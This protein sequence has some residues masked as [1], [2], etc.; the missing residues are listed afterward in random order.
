MRFTGRRL[1]IV[2]VPLVGLLALLDLE[3]LDTYRYPIA[4]PD[5]LVYYLAAQVGS[6]QGWAAIYD[7]SI[8]LPRITAA[9]GRPLPYLNPPQLAWLVLPLT[10]LPYSLAAWAWK[11]LL[12]AAY[13]LSS[14]LAA[15]GIR[16]AKIAWALAG[17]LMLPVFMSLVFGQVSLLIVAVIALAYWLVRTN[18]PWL[19]GLVLAASFLKPQAAFLVPVALLLSS[20]LRTF[21]AWLSASAVLAVVALLAVSW[22]A[23][24]NIAA[25]MAVAGGIPGP[26]QMSLLR[27]L[28]LPLGLAGATLAVG[29]FV[30]VAIRSRPKPEVAVAAGLIASVLVSPYLN[31][32]DL[33]GLVLAAWLVERSNPL[34]WQARVSAAMLLPIFLAPIA[35]LL[36]LICISAWLAS[37]LALPTPPAR[38][39]MTIESIAA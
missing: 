8:F 14:F 36:S 23:V 1:L 20:Q 30:V 18:H 13:T 9:V 7:P 25:S 10:L 17:A 32:Y 35:P 21:I 24:Q 22:S 39:I 37:L 11:G 38:K 28:P 29:V 34:R 6:S 15:P 3:W 31:V 12:A 26:V 4:S 16:L 5:F 19:A 2:G 33:S 27:Q